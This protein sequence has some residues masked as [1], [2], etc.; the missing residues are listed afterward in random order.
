MIVALA[1]RVVAPLRVRLFVPRIVS[2][3]PI[4]RGLFSV[5]APVEVKKVPEAIAKVPVPTGPLAKA[6]ATPV[7]A[8]REVTLVLPPTARPPEL[9]V[10]PPPKRF[11]PLSCSR[12]LPVLVMPVV[13]ELTELPTGAEILRAGVAVAK[14]A[15]LF[16]VTGATFTV[17]LLPARSTAMVPPAAV[18]LAPVPESVAIVPALAEVAVIPPVKVSKPVPVVTLGAVEPPSLSK[19]SPARVWLKLLSWRSANCPRTM[20]VMPKLIWLDWR[21]R[22]LP[23]LMTRESANVVASG[24]AE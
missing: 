24:I 14:A 4:V 2:A 7:V 10:T 20:G 11:A 13:A 5:F 19:V 22:T 8:L 17:R 6:S 9:T 18:T 23:P 1:S 12:P 3:P 16:T 15:V 21:R